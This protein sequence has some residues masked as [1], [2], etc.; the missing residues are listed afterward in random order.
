MPKQQKGNR[1]NTI[2]IEIDG[3]TGCKACFES[4]FVDVFRWDAQAN[5]PIVAY[6]E[7]C[8]ECNKCE[9]ACPENIID[10]IPDYSGIY[11]PAVI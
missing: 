11:W 4:C 5:R 8:V 2:K 6:P 9:L 3:C 1:V 10:V 7:D